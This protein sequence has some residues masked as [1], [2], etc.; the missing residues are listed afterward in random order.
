MDQ[1][2][3]QNAQ[4]DIN[5]EQRRPDQNRLIVERFLI[6][7]RGAGEFA[8]DVGGQA[9]LDLRLVDGGHGVAQRDAFRQIE[10]KRGRRELSLMRQRNRRNAL[11]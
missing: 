9:H 8:G 2:L 4:H 10:R 3:V 5:G 6:G 11:A 1:A 7:L